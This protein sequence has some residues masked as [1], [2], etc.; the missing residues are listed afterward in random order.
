MVFVWSNMCRG[1]TNFTITQVAL[2]DLVMVFAFQ[3]GQIVDQP[4]IIA[5]LAVPILL[6]V[7]FIAAL[8]Y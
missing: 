7:L 8:G 4:L 5:I 1:D 2:N 3:G 6:Q